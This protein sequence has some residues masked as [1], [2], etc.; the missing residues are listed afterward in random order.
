[1]I[2]DWRATDP[3]ALAQMNTPENETAVEIRSSVAEGGGI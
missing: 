3:E 2:Q 1:M